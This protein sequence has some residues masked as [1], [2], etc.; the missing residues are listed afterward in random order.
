MIHYILFEKLHRYVYDYCLALPKS[1]KSERNKKLALNCYNLL[2]PYFFKFRY[3]LVLYFPKKYCRYEPKGFKNL[4]R[5]E[6][7]KHYNWLDKLVLKT[8]IYYIEKNRL[9]KLKPISN[10]KM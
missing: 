2:I 8:R 3:K 9:D 6:I 7:D 10:G 1:R 5:Y 4:M